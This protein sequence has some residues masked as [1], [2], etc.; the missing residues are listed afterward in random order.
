MSILSSFQSPI[1]VRISLSVGKPTCAVMRLTC[2]FFPSVI[3]SLIHEVG[4]SFLNLTGGFRSHNQLGSSIIIAS[5]L[6]V[7]VSAIESRIVCRSEDHPV[8]WF[9][10]RLALLIRPNSVGPKELNKKLEMDVHWKEGI[11]ALDMLLF[12]VLLQADA[13][14][15]Q[16][17]FITL[18]AAISSGIGLYLVSGNWRQILSG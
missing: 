7:L 8:S 6:T 3:I 15:R 13:K 18:F 5:A 2:R 4:M 11:A 14:K 16:G 1:W 12:W 9:L 17:T 10:R